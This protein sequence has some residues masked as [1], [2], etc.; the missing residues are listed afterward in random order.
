M[1]KRV[2]A[3]AAAVSIALAACAASEYVPPETMEWKVNGEAV[4]LTYS[5]TE[6]M[7]VETFDGTVIPAERYVYTCEGGGDYWF[8]ENRLVYLNLSA[9]SAYEVNFRSK[10]EVEA[11]IGQF[12]TDSGLDIADYEQTSLE[13]G[14][15]YCICEYTACSEGLEYETIRANF[16]SWDSFTIM[17]SKPEPM[18]GF[19]DKIY[20]DRSLRDA[21]RDDDMSAH[22]IRSTSFK[23]LGDHL[24][25]YYTVG[26]TDDECVCQADQYTFARK[27]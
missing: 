25:A 16:Y 8:E 20:F 27:K 26:H 10:K 2:L 1:K 4:T 15:N 14:G 22:T 23:W 18:L 21:L 6:D 12:L 11:V 19:F 5:C 24:I 17:L 3:F 13:M 9:E 7:S